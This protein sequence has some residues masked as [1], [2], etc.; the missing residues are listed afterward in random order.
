MNFNIKLHRKGA[1]PRF[2]NDTYCVS[3]EGFNIEFDSWKHVECELP[4]L[5]LFKHTNGVQNQVATVSGV[6][7]EKLTNI[8]EPY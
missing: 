1:A 7:Y 4:Y 2:E 5:K 3:I 8:I 6:T